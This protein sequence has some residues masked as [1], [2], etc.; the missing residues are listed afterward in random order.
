M[1]YPFRPHQLY[2]VFDYETRSEADLKKVGAWE[3]S[4]HPSTRILCV[5]WRIGTLNSLPDI[6]MEIW[7]PF[8]HDFRAPLELVNA[9]KSKTI[10]K[11]A[12]NTGFE[13]AITANVLPRYM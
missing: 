7:S 13:M 6:P 1:T 8:I 10:I 9:L 12:H 2:L 5:A 11:C 3:Y 4:M